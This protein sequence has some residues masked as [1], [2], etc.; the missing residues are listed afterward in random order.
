MVTLKDFV[1][2]KW[3]CPVGGRIVKPRSGHLLIDDGTERI[4]D[5]HDRSVAIPNKIH[6]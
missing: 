1:K 4:I 2:V 5:D 3:L 6:L